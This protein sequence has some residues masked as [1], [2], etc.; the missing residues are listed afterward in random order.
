MTNVIHDAVVQLAAAVGV[1]L[2]DRYARKSFVF[3]GESIALHSDVGSSYTDHEILHEV[4]H[5]MVAWPEQRKRPDYSLTSGS[6]ADAFA[7]TKEHR[8]VREL[9]RREGFKVTSD[10]GDVYHVFVS[11]Q[12]EMLQ[13]LVVQQFCCLLGP[14]FDV[15][16]RIRNSRAD[17]TWT[18]GACDWVQHSQNLTARL[19][20]PTEEN[21]WEGQAKAW[22]YF[23]TGELFGDTKNEAYNT[24]VINASRDLRVNVNRRALLVLAEWATALDSIM[25]P[26]KTL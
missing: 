7:C 9:E 22:H 19:E 13:E 14:R 20:P 15:H 12:E 3:D 25:Y 16:P 8:S 6:V 24:A 5:F 21:R 1:P 2:V 26:W 4:C 23:T 11:E 17:G 18:E 10:V